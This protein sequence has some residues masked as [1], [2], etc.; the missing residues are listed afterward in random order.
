[1]YSYYQLDIRFMWILQVEP[2]WELLFELLYFCEYHAIDEVVVK[3]KAQ[4]TTGIKTHDLHWKCEILVGYIFL[5]TS[6]IV[7]DISIYYSM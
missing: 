7:L 6:K 4:L 5:K 3:A 2:L 1:M